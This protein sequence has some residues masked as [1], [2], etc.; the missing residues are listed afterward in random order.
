MR[1]ARG[2][3]ALVIATWLMSCTPVYATESTTESSECE[4]LLA[5]AETVLIELME[6]NGELRIELENSWIESERI[7][8][9]RAERAAADAARPLLVKVVGLEAALARSRRVTIGIAVGGGVTVVGLG[10]LVVILTRV[11]TMMPPPI[12]SHV[13]YNPP[14]YTP[15]DKTEWAGVVV[16]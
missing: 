1:N 15:P 2:L 8:V 5:E 12:N 4:K 3:T 13:S 10:V 6:E 16:E 7:V 9:E 14:P 11:V